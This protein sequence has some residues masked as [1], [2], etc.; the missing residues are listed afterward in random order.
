M[1]ENSI[2]I[3]CFYPE[4][5]AF[6]LKCSGKTSLNSPFAEMLLF[7]TK[8]SRSGLYL[9]IKSFR[10]WLKTKSIKTAPANMHI[11]AIASRLSK[12]P[13]HTNFKSSLVCG[14]EG[15]GT[16]KVQKEVEITLP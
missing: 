16:K 8:A 1:C 10:K 4:S 12:K 9:L 14:I 5:H 6:G 11:K 7:L 2:G 3:I 15:L 13:P